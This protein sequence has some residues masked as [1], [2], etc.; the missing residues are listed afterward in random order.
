VRVL[1]RSIRH[2]N[3]PR[4]E[5]TPIFVLGSPSADPIKFGFSLATRRQRARAKRHPAVADLGMIP[6]VRGE[7]SGS[8]RRLP[9][10]N[11]I[12]QSGS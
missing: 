4:K 1:G 9:Y 7:S 11:H 10:P 5:P 6:T 3:W 8:C 2:C 12:Q